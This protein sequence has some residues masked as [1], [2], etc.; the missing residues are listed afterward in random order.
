[1]VERHRKPEEPERCSVSGCRNMGERS[2]AA[3]KYQGALP[4]VT[5]S[6]EVGRRVHLCKDHYK[7]F[8]KKTKEER[9]LDRLSW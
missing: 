6:G 1:M 5:L 2:V 3:K 7:E 4:G 9:E 8:R